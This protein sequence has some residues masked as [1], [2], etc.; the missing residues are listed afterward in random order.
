MSTTL[1]LNVLESSLPWMG[2]IFFEHI[3]TFVYFAWDIQSSFD[4]DVH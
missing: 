3:E 2:H 4:F 1:M